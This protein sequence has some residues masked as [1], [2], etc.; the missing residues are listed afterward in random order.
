MSLLA[1]KCAFPRVQGMSTSQGSPRAEQ[2]EDIHVK[3]PISFS[4]VVLRESAHQIC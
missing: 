2:S 1:Q 4:T 3:V